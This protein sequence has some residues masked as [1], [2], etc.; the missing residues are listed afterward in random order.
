MPLIDKYFKETVKKVPHEKAEVVNVFLDFIGGI[1]KDYP[2]EFWLRRVGKCKYGDAL[3]IIKEL[4][5][6]PIKYNK[7]G[8]VINK[9]KKF[10]A[11]KGG[12][13]KNLV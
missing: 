8:T 6:L 13:I 10:N 7:A 12:R 11:H 4:E 2:Y 9:L 5:T 1:S 3:M